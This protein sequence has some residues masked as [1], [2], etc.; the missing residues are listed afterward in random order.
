MPATGYVRA[1]PAALDVAVRADLD[2]DDLR[3]R[4]EDLAESA[5]YGWG[6]TIDFG[7]FT[8]PGLLATKYLRIA[9]AYDQLGWWPPDLSGMR[10]ADVGSYTGGI[11]ALMAARGAAMVH[12][13]DELPEHGAQ[14]GLLA[15]AFGLNNV[16]VVHSSLYDLH[17]HVAPGSLDLIVCAGVLYHLSDMLVG[18]VR[19]RQL[20]RPGG[21]LLLET[22]AVEDFDRSYANYGRFVGG[23]WWQPTARCVADMCE[24]AG[25]DDVALELLQPERLLVRA[26]CGTEPIP[27]VRGMPLRPEDLGRDDRNDLRPRSLEMDELAPALNN[28]AQ[29]GMLG[30]SLGALG[31]RLL[32]LPMSIGYRLRHARRSRRRP[33]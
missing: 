21:T 25:F 24:H 11:S 29:L 9:G 18:L 23:M 26:T 30:R 19:L 27:F 10:V 6:H 14:A 22:N 28:R 33:G 7:A 32:R 12:A 3:R 15:D 13:V 8:Q 16:E 1:R 31:E 20:L 2:A 4:V 5:Q 17:E